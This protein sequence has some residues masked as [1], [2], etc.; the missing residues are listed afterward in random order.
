MQTSPRQLQGLS[1]REASRR[2][3]AGQGNDTSLQT[4]R[5]YW[6]ILRRNLFTF[7]NGA[8]FFL[9]LVLI[10]LGRASDVL[11]L[12]IVVLLN[13]LINLI[14]EIRAKQ[15]LDR[16]ALITRPKASVIRDG[17][18]REIDPSEI[19][20]GDVMVVRPGDQIVVDGTIVSGEMNVDESLLTGESDQIPKQTDDPVYSGSFCISGTAWYEAE[21][22]GAESFASKI[23]AE[24]RKFRRVQT[25]LQRWTNLMIRLL[26]GVEFSWV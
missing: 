23:T 22:V 21:K 3:A 4:S 10:S 26:L 25:P 19:V 7:I 16:I 17:Q 5:T 24:A 13:V 18:E 20:V 15:K 8:Y 12:A 6:D 9:S 11:V 2:R 1:D 14:Q